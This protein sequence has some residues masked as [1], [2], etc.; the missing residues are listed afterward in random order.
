MGEKGNFKRKRKM[1][2]GLL[3]LLCTFLNGC[4]LLD[5]RDGGL[6]MTNPDYKGD[7]ESTEQ[8]DDPEQFEKEETA[9]WLTEEGKAVIAQE[10]EWMRYYEAVMGAAFLGYTAD[11]NYPGQKEQREQEYPYLQGIT[12]DHIVEYEGD[13]WYVIVPEEGW[14]LS[15]ETCIWNEDFTDTEKGDLLWEGKDDLPVILRCNV[16]DLYSNVCVTAQKGKK[17]YTWLPYFLP[18]A[19]EIVTTDGIVQL[20]RDSGWITSGYLYNMEGSWHCDTARTDDGKPFFYDVTFMTNGNAMPSYIWFYGGFLSGENEEIRFYWDG[21]YMF[22]DSSENTMEF[23]LNTPDGIRNGT[24]WLEWEGDR[25]MIYEMEGEAFFPFTGGS[26][27]EFYFH[28]MEATGE[29]CDY[30]GIEDDLLM[31]QPEVIEKLDQG[32]TLL[33]TGGVEM[34]GGEACVI[35]A[36]GTEHPDHFVAEYHYAVSP[37]G[38]IYRMD[39]LTGEWEPF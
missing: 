16:S 18:Y 34:I 28:P 1:L 2:L 14:K 31:E 30:S 29:T 6:G 25:L 9:L 21:S 5:I 24:I 39:Y 12:A 11:Y 35:F 13:E 8:K 15:I 22:C 17:E 3:M 10:R 19:D 4:Q 38:E 32:M 7:T 37:S 23:W 27:E 20:A 33:E 36:I 26:V